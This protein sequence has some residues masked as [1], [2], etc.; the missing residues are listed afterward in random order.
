MSGDSILLFRMKSFKISTAYI[1][2]IVEIQ[3][4]NILTFLLHVLP[5]INKLITSG[6]LIYAY[7]GIS[8]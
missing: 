6:N 3:L 5:V 7:R 8:R 4:L 1:S 2:F